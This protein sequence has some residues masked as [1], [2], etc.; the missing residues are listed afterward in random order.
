[1]HV[2]ELVDRS[3]ELVGAILSEWVERDAET[4]LPEDFQR[5]ARTPGEHVELKAVLS[6]IG[7][8]PLH[9]GVASLYSP[10]VWSMSNVYYRQDEKRRT[11]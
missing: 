7:A 3:S 1:M 6:A 10:H 8:H 11:L 4:G 2:Q 9:D 5:R